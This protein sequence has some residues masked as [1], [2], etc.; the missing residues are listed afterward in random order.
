M[1]LGIP[2]RFKCYISDRVGTYTKI[3]SAVSVA[4]DNKTNKSL[5]IKSLCIA[6]NFYLKITENLISTIIITVAVT[7]GYIRL[8]NR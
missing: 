1:Y 2:I 5:D 7:V 3:I 6:L 4:L 8:P